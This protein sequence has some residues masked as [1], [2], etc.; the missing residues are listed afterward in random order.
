MGEGA[1]IAFPSFQSP[2]PLRSKLLSLPNPSFRCS[3]WA[4]VRGRCDRSFGEEWFSGGGRLSVCA[5]PVRDA[6]RPCRLVSVCV[7]GGGRVYRV[8]LFPISHPP[9][10]KTFILTESLFSMFPVGMS[11]GAVWS[12]FWRG[13]IFWRGGFPCALC[14]CAGGECGP[15]LFREGRD[16][17]PTPVR[18]GGVLK[19]EGMSHAFCTCINSSQ[20]M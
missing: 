4:E 6:A 11:A 15:A 17:G 12:F 1:F 3:P 18:V 16:F 7:C 10:F 13:M 14:P 9:S 20:N 19:H 2:I 5:P 8:S